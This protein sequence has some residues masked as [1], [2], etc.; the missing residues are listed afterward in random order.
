MWTMHERMLAETSLR[1]ASNGNM[2]CKLVGSDHPAAVALR[3]CLEAD[4]KLIETAP[5]TQAGLRALE[6]H[7]RGRHG[8]SARGFIRA[9]PGGDFM[10]SLDSTRNQKNVDWLISQRA[11]EIAA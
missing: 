8:Q 1:F 9:P 6:A 4:K 10:F 7:L 3:A 2:I 11:S 5:T